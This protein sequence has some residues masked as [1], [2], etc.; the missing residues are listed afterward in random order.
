MAWPFGL[1]SSQNK[2]R[3]KFPREHERVH[4]QG[5]SC[6]LG[7]VLDISGGGMRIRT[8][9]PIGVAKGDSCNF[10]VRSNRH[11][12]SVQG[13]IMWV[14]RTGWKTHEIG[15]RWLDA[16]PVHVQ[17]LL[18]LA[19]YGFVNIEETKGDMP[20]ASNGSASSAKPNG[21]TNGS[22][23]G[24]ANGHTSGAKSK[25]AGRSVEDLYAILGVSRVS[26]LDEIHS[27]F[28]A[29]AR[30]LHPDVNKEAGAQERFTEVSKAYTV[31]R[32]ADSRRKYDIL[33]AG[34]SIHPG[35]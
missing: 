8:D 21:S 13:M 15:V 10:G 26:K 30:K 17:L 3:V 25:A 28:R 27:A 16:S 12:V 35:T 7:H 33:L 22:S 6:H 11:Q 18:Q 1:N 31:L 29:L 19:R 20:P 9:G 34:G 24:S 5:I 32:D 14:K 2:Q 4:A 23:N